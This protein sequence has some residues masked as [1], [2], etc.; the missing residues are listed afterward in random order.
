M[1]GPCPLDPMPDMSD[2][3]AWDHPE[4]FTLPLRVDA[5]CIDLMGH[6]NN[7]VYLKWLED[8]AWA[9]SVALGLGPAQYAELGHGVVVRQHELTYLQA[10]RLDED[11]LLATWITGVDKLS[12]HRAFQFVRVSD[13][14][15]VFRGRTHY[16]CVDIEQGRVRRMPER[17]LQTYAPA[18]L[19]PA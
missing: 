4:P 14:A 8:V 12:L 3:P 10:T 11:V 15:T 13:G 17:F 9:H 16:V 7:V 19:K 18:V 2:A 1:I 6:T 5:S